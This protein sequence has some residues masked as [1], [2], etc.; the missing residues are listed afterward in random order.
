ME[1]LSEMIVKAI[2][3]YHV[4]FMK[5]KVLKTVEEVE[6]NTDAA[7]KY[8]AGAGVADELINKLTFPDGESFYLDVKDG[9]RGYNSD[10]ARGADTFRPFKIPLQKIHLGNGTSNS[11]RTFSAKSI[12]GYKKLTNA[13][14]AIVATGASCFNYGGTGGYGSLSLSYDQANG[15]VT[16]N[17]YVAF[18][19]YADRPQS[20]YVG[21]ALYAYV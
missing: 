14:F 12:K 16:V 17:Q 6:A 11:A 1:K 10:P 3:K 4:G 19:S 13:N 7:D 8:I 5:K 15:I 21:Y 9:E 20:W 18:C 2:E